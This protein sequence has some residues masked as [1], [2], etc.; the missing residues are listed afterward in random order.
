M[1]TINWQPER[2]PFLKDGERTLHHELHRIRSERLGDLQSVLNAKAPRR[3]SLDAAIAKLARKPHGS[4]LEV[5]AGDAWASAYLMTQFDFREVYIMEIDSSAVE[6]LIPQTLDLFNVD[7]SKVTTVLGSFNQIPLA[8]HFDYII[9]MGAL[10]HSANLLRTMDALY[11]A[12]KPGGVLLSQEPSM[13]DETPNAFYLEKLREHTTFPEGIE[14]LNEKRSDIFYRRCEYRV[15]GLHAG[16][17]M[18]VAELSQ[19]VA[20]VESEGKKAFWKWFLPKRP[21]ERGADP[22]DKNKPS[23]IFITAHKPRVPTECNHRWVEVMP[24]E[25]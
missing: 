25:C 18:E 11:R 14:I 6:H 3:A 19:V 9:A 4:L 7:T 20:P 2:D 15:A 24:K 10:H 23:N 16:F 21:A 22:P 13:L 17:E 12:L 5:G 1:Q 8:N